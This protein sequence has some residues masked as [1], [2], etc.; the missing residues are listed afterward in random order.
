MNI[1]QCNDVRCVLCSKQTTF[2]TI[3]YQFHKPKDP[4]APSSQPVDPPFTLLTH[5][6]DIKKTLISLIRDRLHEIKSK[7]KAYPQWM[8]DLIYPDKDDPE[9]FTHPQCVMATRLDPITS[10]RLSLR[11]KR[12][13]FA[14]DP[15]Q[16]LATSLVHTQF[17]EFPTIE[18]WDEFEGTVV[19][20]QG[21]VQQEEERPTKRRRMNPRAGKKAIEGL[22][23]GYGS[24]QEDEQEEESQNVLAGLNEY[25]ESDGGEMTSDPVNRGDGEISSDDD[26]EGEVDPAVLLKL[27]RDVRGR[28]TCAFEENE[29]VDWGDGDLDDDEPEPE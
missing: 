24:S 19:D 5:R 22:L 11:S 13:Y 10:R 8:K 4:L 2:L 29:A 17:V 9:A 23:G 21:I 7:S 3:E 12:V 6:N 1:L 15:K 16:P 14:L 20:A 27:L 18:V 25:T 26:G 28:D